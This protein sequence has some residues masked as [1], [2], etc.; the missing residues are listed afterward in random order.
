MKTEE[1][2]DEKK[3]E[4]LGGRALMVAHM[5]NSLG[6]SKEA[7]YIHDLLDDWNKLTDEAGL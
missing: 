3:R 6:H 7:N 2:S 1:I 5:L 4:I